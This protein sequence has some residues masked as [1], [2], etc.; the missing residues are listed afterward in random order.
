M[1]LFHPEDIRELS[2]PGVVSRQLLTPESAPESRVT[3]TERGPLY[4]RLA[5]R[6]S[7]SAPSPALRALRRLRAVKSFRLPQL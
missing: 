2:N 3:L 6:R 7:M 1:E 5:V 4:S